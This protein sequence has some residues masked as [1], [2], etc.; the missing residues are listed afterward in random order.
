VQVF[1]TKSIENKLNP[2]ETAELVISYIQ[3]IPYVLV[4]DET[5]NQAIASGNE[6]MR[7]YHLEGR[8]CLPEIPAGVQSPYEFSH[9]LEGDCDTRS[10]FAFSLLSSLNIPCSIW[11][12]SVYGH[13]VVGIGLPAGGNNFKYSNGRRHFGT[14][15][16]ATGFR[17]GM[18]APDQGDMDNW[19]IALE[20]NF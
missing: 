2:V 8:P 11:V 1:K 6:F 12:S 20:T 16:T 17:I 4:H 19:K 18:M 5:C 13:S 9:N 14:E 10:L 15:L 3:Q 7:N